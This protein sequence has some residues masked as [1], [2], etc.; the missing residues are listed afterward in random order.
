MDKR[1]TIMGWLFGWD[2]RKALIKHC[3][4]D[5]GENYKRIAHTCTG[6]NLWAVFERLENG[7]PKYRFIALFLMQNGGKGHGWGYKDMDESCGPCEKNCPM[8]YFELAPFNAEYNGAG[9]AA[10]W[11]DEVKEFWAAKKTAREHVATMKQGEIFKSASG[12]TFMFL[13]NYSP[14]FVLASEVD[15]DGR[16]YRVRKT[17]I[18]REAVLA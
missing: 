17:D 7:L 5:M 3:V 14:S 9:Y 10:K 16:F 13:A 4:E 1:R 11:R 2:D 6:N 12:K 15:S 18:L 8:K